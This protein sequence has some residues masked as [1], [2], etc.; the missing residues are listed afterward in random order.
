MAD[1]VIDSNP[2]PLGR[3]LL[4]EFW[5]CRRGLDDADIVRRAIQEATARIHATVLHL[6]VHEF[7]PQ[8]V[9]GVATLAESHL[10]IHT[11]PERD[12]LAADVFT[13]GETTNLT[14]AFDV[15]AMHFEPSEVEVFE[16]QRGLA[17]GSEIRRLSLEDLAPF[18]HPTTDHN[19]SVEFGNRS[20]DQSQN[21]H[22]GRAGTRKS[23]SPTLKGGG[24]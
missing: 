14:D 9:T 12:Y 13:C 11:W 10:S 6:H 16:V 15:L 8:G 21:A 5:H 24:Q 19:R 4:I 7:S 2:Q 20:A 17:T 1:Q 23:N 18:E 3:H 22:Q